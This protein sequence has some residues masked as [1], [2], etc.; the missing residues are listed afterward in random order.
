MIFNCLLS[1]RVALL[2]IRVATLVTCS[3]DSSQSVSDTIQ[4]WQVEKRVLTADPVQVKGTICNIGMNY[5]IL[6]GLMCLAYTLR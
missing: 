4:D 3:A 1:D 2:Q 5:R 6:L